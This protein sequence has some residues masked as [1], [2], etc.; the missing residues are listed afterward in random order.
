MTFIA[1]VLENF[2]KPLK[3]MEL[4]EPDDLEPGQVWVKFE[5]ASICGAQINE[6]SGA[7]LA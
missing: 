6:I 3:L 5:S 7:A 1:A 4:R 2:N